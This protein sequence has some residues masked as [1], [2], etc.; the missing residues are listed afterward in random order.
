MMCPTSEPSE[1]Q[2]HFSVSHVIS[3]RLASLVNHFF[4]LSTVAHMTGSESRMWR[5]PAERGTKEGG[6]ESKGDLR[7]GRERKRA[8]LERD[9]F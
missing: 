1:S 2:V 4:P 5:K 3:T 6:K 7:V 9:K 8:I